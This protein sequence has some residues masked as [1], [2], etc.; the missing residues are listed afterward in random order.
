[1]LPWTLSHPK[2]EPSSISS[3]NGRAYSYLRQFDTFHRQI[4]AICPYLLAELMGFLSSLKISEFLSQ[5]M[6]RAKLFVRKINIGSSI[7]AQGTGEFMALTQLW[8]KL[9]SK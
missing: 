9:I 3:K 2:N 6:L 5:S 4:L 8:D 1:M 7:Q